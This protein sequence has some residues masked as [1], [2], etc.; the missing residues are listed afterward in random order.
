VGRLQRQVS[1]HSR[2]GGGSVLQGVDLSQPEEAVAGEGRGGQEPQD[3]SIPGLHALRHPGHAE[4][5][6]RP[7][8]PPG[9]LLCAAV[10]RWDTVRRFHAYGV[11]S[12]VK[13][14]RLSEDTSLVFVTLFTFCV[15]LQVYVTLARSKNF[16][17]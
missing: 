9:T 12:S 6:I 13:G 8:A 1:P 7:H 17:S 16:A 11:E 4:P 2:A 5:R 15:L 14:A 3:E 10:S